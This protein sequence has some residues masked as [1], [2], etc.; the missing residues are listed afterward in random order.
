MGRH[1]ADLIRMAI[2]A[3]IVLVSLLVAAS[4]T[5]NPVEFAIFSELEQLPDWSA[6]TWQ[7]LTW[8]GS[9]PGVVGAAGLALYFGRLRMGASLAA[10][11]ATSWV[12]TLILH[13]LTVP[14][15]LPTG[16]VPAVLRQPPTGGFDFPSVHVAVIAALA[17][18]ASPYL[19]RFARHGSWLLVVLVGAAD[20]FSG[21]NLPVGI[22]AGAALG[23]GTG[24]LGHLVLGAPG[25]RTSEVSVR[26]ALDDLGLDGAQ[27]AAVPRR[28]LRPYAYDI[29]TR[30]GE[31]MQMKVV[32]RMHRLAGP[33]YRLRM[34]LASFEVERE[35]RLSTPRHEVEHEAYVTLLAARA[36]VGTLPVVAAGKIEHG[37]PFLIRQHVAGVRLSTLRGK[38]VDDAVLSRTWQDVLVLGEHHVAHHDLRA[39]NILIDSDGRPRI[40]DFTLS[41]VGGPPGQLAQAVA[42]MLVTMASVVGVGRAVDSAVREVPTETLQDALPHLQWL[43]LPRRLRRQLVEKQVAL[44]ELRA[45]L[46]EHLGTRLPS[47]RSPVRPLTVAVTLTAGLAVYLLLPALS[48][49]DQ[50]RNSLGRADWRWMGVAI[51][52]GFLGVVASGVSILGSSPRPLPVGKTMVVQL[53]A[54]FTG[55]TTAAGIGFYGINIAYLQRLGLGRAN[56]VGVVLLNRA[57]VGAI[58]AV[59]AALGVLVIGSAV[60]LASVRIP[61]GWPLILIAAVVL[62]GAAA[63]GVSPIGRRRVWRPMATLLHQLARDLLPTL[64][65]P[66]PALQLLGGSVVFL[67]LQAAGLAATLA[68]FQPSFPL[69]PVLAVYV[70]GSTVGQ[71]APT[72][73]GLGP[74]EAL[75]VAGLIA[76]GVDPTIAVAAVLTSRALTFWLPALAGLVAFRLLHHHDVV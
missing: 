75:T 18:A 14:R 60:P 36:G 24:A 44:A 53:G 76:I 10:A 52:T 72:P 30:S 43:A 68:A 51:A 69:I 16:L 63:F 32:R 5:I 35:P 20:V 8:S 55:R 1:P 25:R 17:T 71:L 64:R 48:S 34:V 39:K 2:A 29:T 45:T 62:L 22:V 9:W 73:G 23:W 15:P 12:L 13:W 59:A 31:C 47:F 11:G 42:D 38:Q 58:T 37:P 65:R 56:A 7:V 6:R 26:M 46:A 41:R 27:I 74:V 21:H 28:W 61:T 40:T 49:I 33:A 66:V 54:A 3:G 4:R 19:S 57:V 50:V 70:V 67:A